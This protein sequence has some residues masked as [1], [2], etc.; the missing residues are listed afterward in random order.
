MSYALNYIVSNGPNACSLYQGKVCKYSLLCSE[1]M[2]SF[3]FLLSCCLSDI[4]HNINVI[5]FREA[6]FDP[7]Y[8]LG[9]IPLIA[10]GLSLTFKF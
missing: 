5:N 7:C 9:P 4:H 10:I 1:E 3:I 6:M 2:I 8:G